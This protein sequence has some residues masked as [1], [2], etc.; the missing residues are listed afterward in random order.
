MIVAILKFR[1]A[2]LVQQDRV[3]IAFFITPLAFVTLIS[4]VAHAYPNWASVSIVSGLIL[5]AALLLRSTR[6]FWLNASIGLGVVVQAG[7]LTTDVISNQIKLPALGN[8]YRRTIGLKAYAERIGHIAEDR[9][10]RAIASDERGKFAVLRYYWRNKPVQ[11]LSWGTA[12][13]PS[14]DVAHPLTQSAPQ[15]IL[16]V[17]ECPDEARVKPFFNDIQPL[18]INVVPVAQGADRYFFAVIVSSPRGPIGILRE[19]GT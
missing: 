3:M 14:F 1:S 17:S 6:L 12:N 11:I 19:C 4:I 2:L 18:G 8:P 7:L 9:G 13:S 10:A 16:F 5:T 15:P